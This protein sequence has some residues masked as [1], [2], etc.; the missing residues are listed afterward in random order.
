M[1]FAIV[2]NNIVENIIVAD[3]AFVQ[4]FYPDAIRIDNLENRPSVGWLYQDNE[5]IC[6]GTTIL[7]EITEEI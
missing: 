7:Q 5:F 6:T 2:Q 3:E 1:E 4:E